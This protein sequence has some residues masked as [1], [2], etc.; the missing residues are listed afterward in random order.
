M[1]KS[2]QTS[3]VSFPSVLEVHTKKESYF[4]K[5]YVQPVLPAAGKLLTL[6]EFMQRESG[7]ASV[8][9]ALY[10][11]RCLDFKKR[12]VTVAGALQPT[13]DLSTA[14]AV[15]HS[16]RL[17]LTVPEHLFE[18]QGG[19]TVA[20]EQRVKLLRV[21]ELSTPQFDPRKELMNF[22]QHAGK[23]MFFSMCARQSAAMFD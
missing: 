20:E 5:D 19:N 12:G 3:L 1:T 6:E 14:C 8:K 22:I 10:F 13:S 7:Q 11:N 23:S 15:T 18:P 16:K 9:A 21:L 2:M 4:S 17:A